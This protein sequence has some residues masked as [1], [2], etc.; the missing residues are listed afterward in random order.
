MRKTRL[1][2]HTVRRRIRT[3]RTPNRSNGLRIDAGYREGDGVAALRRH[4]G[5]IAGRPTAPPRSSGITAGSADV[6][7]IVT[8]IP[9]LS[10]LVTHPDVRA[11]AI[12]RLYRTRLSA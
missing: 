6:R 12:D 1:E 2:F 8:N 4:A 9:F 11:N 3:W 10:A 5:V 7:G